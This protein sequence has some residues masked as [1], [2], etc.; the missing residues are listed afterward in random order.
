MNKEGKY[1][2]IKLPSGSI[3][4]ILLNC[5]ATLGTLSNSDHKNI[6]LGKAGRKRWLGIRPHVRGVAM[7][8]NSHPH[9]G[10]EGRSGTGMP[11]K[12]PWGKRAFG[13]TR[14]KNKKSS[15]LIIRG[16]K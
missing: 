6:K 11:P 4:L 2:Q 16:R 7:S 9:G 15:R 3:R 14:N 10:G 8:P 1:A 5:F 13:K 12:T